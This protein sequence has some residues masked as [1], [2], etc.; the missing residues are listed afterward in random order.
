MYHLVP[1]ILFYLETHSFLVLYAEINT[2]T[3]SLFKSINEYIIPKHGLKDLRDDLKDETPSAILVFKIY[4]TFANTAVY[5]MIYV[6]VQKSNILFSFQ[7]LSNNL[8]L[9]W[10]KY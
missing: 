1:S 10:H 2:P 8:V 5:Y 9:L 3:R 6:R 4:Y 7:K